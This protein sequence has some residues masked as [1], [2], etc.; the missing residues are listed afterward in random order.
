MG[1]HSE[2]NDAACAARKNADYPTGASCDKQQNRC[3][4]IR[5]S[6]RSAFAIRPRRLEQ[7]CIDLDQDDKFEPDLALLKG[8][9]DMRRVVLAKLPPPS[10]GRGDERVGQRRLILTYE[11]SDEALE[12]AATGPRKRRPHTFFLLNSV[13]LPDERTGKRLLAFSGL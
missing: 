1:N 10:V 12:A 7:C 4:E 6:A 5:Q 8:R 11:V 13:D 3:P 2:Q 9:T